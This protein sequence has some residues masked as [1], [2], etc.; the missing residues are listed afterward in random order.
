LGSLEAILST[1]EGAATE[2][3]FAGRGRRPIIGA[4]GFH[5]ERPGGEVM[6][7]RRHVYYSG[8]VQGVG[9]RY[10]ARR[11]ARGRGVTGLVRNLADGR[12]E[13]VAEGEG[14]AVSEFLAAVEQAMGSYIR[15]VETLEE[16][17]TGE[18]DGFGVAF[19]EG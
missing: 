15:D 18:F 11:L 19:D 13:V 1:G 3:S 2:N 14:G 16:P 10:T 9:F 17:P 6:L 12:V 7:A 8:T 5:V 4:R